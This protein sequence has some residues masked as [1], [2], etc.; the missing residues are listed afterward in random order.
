MNRCD[1]YKWEEY[2]EALDIENDKWWELYSRGLISWD[3]YNEIIS[4]W[5]EANRPEVVEI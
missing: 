2:N 5:I 3:E 4:K 1:E